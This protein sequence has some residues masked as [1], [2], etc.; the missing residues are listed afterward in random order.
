MYIDVTKLDDSKLQDRFDEAFRAISDDRDT[1]LKINEIDVVVLR[2]ANRA[3]KVQVTVY[4]LAEVTTQ[5]QFY[6]AKTKKVITGGE[7]IEFE[8]DGRG[9]AGFTFDS[10][11][12]KNSNDYV[13][14][15][16][17]L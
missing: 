6:D 1:D 2:E 8:V 12:R 7:K 13:V 4:G 3:V 10:I 11:E 16:K 9:N 15:Y 17:P 14:V 5:E